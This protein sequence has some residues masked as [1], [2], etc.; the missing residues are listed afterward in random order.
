MMLLCLAILFSFVACEREMTQTDI[1]LLLSPDQP[2]FME[3]EVGERS[4]EIVLQVDRGDAYFWYIVPV[5]SDEKIA[6]LHYERDGGAGHFIYTVEGLSAGEA[7]VYFTAHD[8]AVS[9][10]LI[11]VRVKQPKESE[12]SE[13]EPTP[14]FEGKDRT[15]Y[16]TKSGTRYHLKQ[17]CAGENAVETRLSEVFLTNPPCKICANEETEP[18]QT[19]E[20]TALSDVDTVYITPSGK[21]YHLSQSHAGEQATA[22]TVREAESAG[23]EACRI[24]VP[25]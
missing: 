25:E 3:L 23:K 24:C 17:S 10:E 20:K 15:V 21:K 6:V 11:R 7:Y 8:G 18:P 2:R 14:V 1:A 9:S 16:V 12:P 19:T 5:S 4:A 22:T 13:T